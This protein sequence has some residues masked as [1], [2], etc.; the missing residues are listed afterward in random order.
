[1][2][3]KKD[4]CNFDRIIILSYSYM[5]KHNIDPFMIFNLTTHLFLKPVYSL[6]NNVKIG[7]IFDF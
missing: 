5:K 4:Y 2:L 7:I 3:L 1:M 6:G